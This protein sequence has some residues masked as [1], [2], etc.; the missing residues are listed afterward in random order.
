MGNCINLSLSKKME[1][2]LPVEAD[3]KLPAPL[4]SWPPGGEFAKGRIDLG[5][6][7]VCQVSTFEQV[8]VTREGGEDGLGAAFFKPSP[9]P[10]GF[11]ALGY[12]AQPNNRPLFGWVLAGRPTDDDG[13]SLA[14]PVDYSLVW[15]SESSSVKQDVHGYFWLPT[16]PEG[17][18]AVGLVVTTSPEKPALDEVRCVRSDLTDEAENDANIWSTDG[19]SVDVSRPVSRGINASGVMAGTFSAQATGAASASTLACL[20]NTASNLTSMPNLAQVDALMSAY[21][22]WIYFHPDEEY[23]PSSVSWFFD[24]GAL[25]YQKGNQIPTPIDSNGGN[26]PQ[27]GSNDGEYWIDLAA[28]DGQKEKLKKGDISVT[29]LYLHIKPMLGATFTDVAIWLFYPFNGPARAKVSFV[30]LKLGKIGQHV[31]DW[32][33][34]TLR[35]SNFTG[36]LWKVYFAEHSGGTWVDASQL[37]FQEGNNKPVGYASL[38]GHA[39]YAKPGMVLQGNTKLGIGIRND[40]ATGQGIDSGKSFEVVAAEYLGAAAGTEPPWLNYMREWG[41]KIKYDI[42]KELKSVEKWLPGKMKSAFESVIEGLPDEVLGEEG[43]TGPKDKNSWQ[44]DE[45]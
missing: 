27:G 32:E 26:L 39:M 34:V 40:T 45:K 10:D 25:L 42:A 33:H 31:G 43:P 19:F 30:N 16:P 5:G 23:L 20:K 17:Y 11:S 13:A 35:I 29:K 15:S 22:P 37:E 1:Q 3:F 2:P 28:E 44:N 4:P 36:E 24:N 12:Y 9:I 41:P 6:L 8:W 18:R 7:E 21:S 14:K 38:H